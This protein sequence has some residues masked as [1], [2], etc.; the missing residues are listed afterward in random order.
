MTK[1]QT[2]SLSQDAENQ[3]NYKCAHTCPTP[4]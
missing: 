1:T 3:A 2:H 4:L